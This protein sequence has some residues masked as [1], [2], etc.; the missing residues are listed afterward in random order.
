MDKQIVASERRTAAVIGLGYVG[1]PTAALLASG[2]FQTLGVDINEELIAKLSSSTFKPK[3]PGLPELLA[4]ATS[5]GN[6]NFSKTLST[7]DVYVIAVPTPISKDKSP[8]MDYVLSATSSIASV[9]E[10]GQLVILESTSPPGAT[11]K[12]ADEISRLRPDLDVSGQ[13][14]H[15]IKFAYCPERVLPGNAIYEIVNNER[16]VGGL[17]FEG[18]TAAKDVYSSFAKGHIVLCTDREAELAK[19]VENSYRDVN[20]AFANE[21]ARISTQLGVRADTVIQLANRH[22]RVDI[23]SPGVGVGGHCIS[24]DPWFLANAAPE[25]AKLI[26]QA[27]SI[28][29]EQP[30]RIAAEVAQYAKH[31]QIDRIICMGVSYKP[32]SDDI[33]ESPSIQFVKTL[34]QICDWAKL[35]VYDPNVEDG[36]IQKL[37][38]EEV[39]LGLPDEALTPS[40]LAVILV[41]HAEFAHVDLG[42]AR[43]S[44]IFGRGQVR[45]D[46]Q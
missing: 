22:P 16:L 31:H 26:R 11:A 15:S 32:N 42:K 5:S 38:G 34:A 10:A 21:I 43:V 13:G 25:S 20:I 3:E 8:D 12:V 14:T 39:A 27:R 44:T 28:N 36:E 35:Y 23:L 29:D 17:T 37:F 33:R 24:V 19:L 46:N 6:L 1:L 9:I 30:K 7:C 2:G 18:A 40:D 4:S 45:S 41:G